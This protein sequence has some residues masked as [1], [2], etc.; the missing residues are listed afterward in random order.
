MNED[1]WL[2]CGDPMRMLRHL[3]ADSRGR[4][5]LLLAAACCARVWTYLPEN[6]RDWVRLVEDAAEGRADPAR[7]NDHWEGVEEALSLLSFDEYPNHADGRFAALIEVLCVYWELLDALSDP[8]PKASSYVRERRAY[9][10][11]VRDIYGNPFRPARVDPAWLAW[12]EG[13]VPKIARAIYDERAFE[14]LPILADA[15]ED[16]GCDEAHILNH[17]R[18]PGVHVRGCWVVDLLLGKE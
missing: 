1:E 7:L 13:T 4:K 9:A 3:R 12:N 11:L 10:A 5:S 14:R 18:G 2:R 8:N 17:C 6:C 15:L 16:A